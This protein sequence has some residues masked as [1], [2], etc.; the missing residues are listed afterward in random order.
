MQVPIYRETT[1]LVEA[2]CQLLRERGISAEIRNP[3]TTEYWLL[4]SRMLQAD[5]LVPEER[6][7]RAREILEEWRQESYRRVDAAARPFLRQV[8]WAL[9][10]FVA[11]VALVVVVGGFSL[12]LRGRAIAA[13]VVLVSSLALAGWNW[14]RR[15]R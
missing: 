6:A 1:D 14:S 3:P 2:A 10:L 5:L 13:S 9:P 12:G 8:S 4:S 15:N 11:A 7:A